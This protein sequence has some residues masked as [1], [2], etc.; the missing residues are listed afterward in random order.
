MKSFISVALFTLLFVSCQK[1]NA[2][3][4][5]ATVA[6]P[7]APLTERSGVIFCPRRTVNWQNLASQSSAS[8]AFTGNWSQELDQIANRCVLNSDC[9]NPGS[10][11]TISYCCDAVHSLLQAGGHAGSWPNV[12]PQGQDYLIAYAINWGNQHLPACSSGTPKLVAVD[13]YRDVLVP[14]FIGFT[15]RYE[16]CGAGE[17][18]E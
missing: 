3:V 9:A 18:Q 15:F 4:P 5:D 14:T 8:S 12:T 11:G 7:A 10:G 6:N 13:F 17:S 16:C 2:P 1:D